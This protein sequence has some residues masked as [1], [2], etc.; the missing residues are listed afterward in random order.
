MM[1]SWAISAGAHLVGSSK[2]CLL[3]TFLLVFMASLGYQL[4]NAG[5]FYTGKSTSYKTLVYYRKHFS[6]KRSNL[7]IFLLLQVD[8]M[9]R[10][11]SLRR[12]FKNWHETDC[13]SKEH[14]AWSPRCIYVIHIKC[15]ALVLHNARL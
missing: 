6:V 5:F 13:A 4:S 1:P 14:C 12:R 8:V 15:I 3:G 10:L 2:G 11:V 9:A 7:L